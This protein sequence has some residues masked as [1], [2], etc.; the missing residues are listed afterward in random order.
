MFTLIGRPT[1]K[2]R[3]T[4]SGEYF[5]IACVRGEYT[6]LGRRF[7]TLARVADVEFC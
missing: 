2:F 3:I 4:W 1:T 7:Q 5:G 6:Y